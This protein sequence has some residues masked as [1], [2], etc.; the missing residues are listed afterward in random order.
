MVASINVKSDIDRVVRGLSAQARRQIPF[1]TA[2]ALTRTAKAVE[3]DLR[4][5]MGKVFDKPAPYVARGTFVQSAKK[6]ALEATVGM[7]DQANGRGASP[8]MYVRESF[9]G[10]MRGQKPFEV[11]LRAMGALP[12]GWK[13]VPGAGL[14]LDAYGAPNRK[15]LA[16]VLGAM[17]S[18]MRAYKG[19]GKRMQAVGY[20]A[21]L[22][23][24]RRASTRHLAPGI[25]RRIQSG[26]GGALQPVLIFVQQAA[27][28]RRLD[29]QAIGDRTVRS[30]FAAHFRQALGQAMESAR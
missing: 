26:I 5:E 20:F 15:Q 23:G 1:A 14:K 27:Y 11:A 16:E 21:V 29:I 28:Q 19:R 3:N 25:Y 10:G 17:R 24:A 8:A 4:G 30:E 22:P 6:T 12:A 13:T 18:G 2:V 9:G 7:R